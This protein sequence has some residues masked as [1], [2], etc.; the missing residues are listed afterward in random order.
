MP[1]YVVAQY[2]RSPDYDSYRAAAAELNRKY[3]ARILTQSGT[4]QCIEGEWIATAMVIIEFASLTR[5]REF[6]TSRAYEEVKALRRGAPPITIV[7]V[8]GAPGV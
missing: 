8:D 6:L 4:E 2:R 7:V 5:A 3:D 1:A